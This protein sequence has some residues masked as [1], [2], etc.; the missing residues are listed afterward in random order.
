MFSTKK[1]NISRIFDTSTE[2][3]SFFEETR[4]WLMVIFREVLKYS[5]HCL[6]L[7]VDSIVLGQA[8]GVEH[9]SFHS[10]TELLISPYNEP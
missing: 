3:F 10:R 8:A 6:R 2:V 4:V 5:F 9:V 1:V 7:D